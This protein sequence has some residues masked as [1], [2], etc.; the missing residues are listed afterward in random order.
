MAFLSLS[1]QLVLMCTMSTME[2]GVNFV[3]KVLSA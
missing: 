3:P 2:Y 1:T